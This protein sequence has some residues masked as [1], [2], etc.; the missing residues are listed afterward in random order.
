MRRLAL[1]RCR[2]SVI[3]LL[4]VFMLLQNASIINKLAASASWCSCSSCWLPDMQM[5]VFFVMVLFVISM[6]ALATLLRSLAVIIC[7]KLSFMLT[8]L[9]LFVLAGDV[10]SSSRRCQY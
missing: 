7:N 6:H 5:A 2:L 4:I 1:T 9:L 3:L 8:L 10:L